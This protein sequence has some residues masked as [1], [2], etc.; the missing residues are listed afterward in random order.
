KN[1]SPHG[2]P[3]GEILLRDQFV[4]YV[5]DCALRR[6]LKQLVRRQPTVTLFDVRS[7]ALRWEREG[8]PGGVRGRSQ[9]VPSAYGIQYGVQGR[10]HL[11][12][13]SDGSAVSE[14]SE[15]RDMLRKQQQQLNQLS[16]SMSQLQNP[17][18]HPRPSRANLICRR[19]QKPGHFARDC[20]GE[21]MPVRPPPAHVNSA[22]MRAVGKLVPTEL[23]GRNLVGRRIGSNV[24]GT[25][26]MSRFM[27]SCP[28]LVVSM[29][30]VQVP[31]LVDTGSMVSTMTESCFM[32]NFGLWGQEQLR[33]CNWLQL[34]AANGLTIPYIGYL[35]LDVELCGRV[36]LGCGILVVRDPP[37]GVCAQVPGVLGMNILSRCYRELLGQHGTTLFDLPSVSRA[38]SFVFQALQHCHQVDAQP[39]VDCKGRVRVRGRRVCRITGGTMKFVAATCSVQYASGTVLFEPPTSGLPAGLLASPAL[40]RLDSGTVYVPIVNVGTMDVVLYA[41]TVIGTVNQVD[42]VSLPPEVAEVKTVTAKVSAQVVQVSPTVQEQIATLD[43]CVVRRRTGQRFRRIPPSEYEVVKAHINQLLETQVIR[44]S[45]SPYASPIVLVKKK[46]GSLRMCVDYRRLNSKTR[47]DAFPL[48]RIEETLDSLAG[49]RWFSTMDLASGYNQVPVAEGDKSKTAF[50][51]PFGLFEWNR[52]PFGLC[53]APSTFQHLME[54]LFGD[55]Q[56]QSLLLYL[57]DIIVF[58]SSVDQHLARLEVVLSRLQ[59]EGLKAKLSKCAFFKKEVHYLGH[60]ISSEGVSTDPGKVEAVAQ[61]PRPTNVSELRSFLGFASYYRRFVEGFAKLAAPLHRLVAQLANPKPLKRSAR[62]FAEAW[63]A[64]CQC[65]FEGLKGKLTTAPVLAYADFS[66]PFILEVDASHGGLGA[67]LS[68][69][70]QG[71]VRPIAYGSRSLRPTERNTTNYSS[72]KL[73]FLAL[74]WAMTE[75]FREYLLGHK[76]VVFTDNNPLSYLTSAKLGAMEQRWAAQVAAFDFEIKY[77]SGKS[78]RNADALSRQNF[79]GTVEVQELCPGVAVP[80]VL[81]QAA[82]VELVAQVNQVSS[83][84]CS[85]VSDMGAQ[86]IVDPVIGELLVFW[87]RKSPPTPEERKKLSKLAIILFRQWDRLVETDG[88]LYRRVFRP[89]G[90]E[91]V[92]Q[93][94]LPAVMKHEVLTQLHQQHGHQGVERTSQLV[95]QRCY[96]PGMSADIARWCQECERCQCAK[97]FPTA[98]GSFMGH[99]L[100]ARPNEILALD[101]TVLE[102]SRSGLENVL[103][104]TDIFT[105]YTL[106]VPTRDQ[107]AETVAQVLVVEWFCKFG[108]PGRIH[109]DQGRNFESTLI[110]QLCSLYGVEKSRTTPY[111]PAGNG[112]CERFN[113]TLH[114]LLRTLPLSKKGDWPFCLPQA[115]FAYNTTP[116]QAT[117]E[118]PHFLMFGQEPRLPVDFLLGRVQEPF[119]GSVHRWILEQQDR[120]QV[121]FKGAHERMGAAADRR[122]ARHDLQVKEAPL[123][124]GQLVYLRDY[125]VRGRCK[126]QDLW[127]SV[128][129]Q[130]LRAP[131][132]GGPVYTIAPTTDLSKVKQVHRSLL[133][134]LIGQDPPL[135]LPDPLVIEPLQ[136][137]EEEHDEEDLFVLAPETPQD[138]DHRLILMLFLLI[139]LCTWIQSLTLCLMLYDYRIQKAE[140]ISFCVRLLR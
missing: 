52:M 44:E 25:D 40:L 117:G 53:N 103:V 82:Q 126:I 58:S 139:K 59:R 133:K 23:Q 136:P 64:E 111:H 120:L 13:S 8:M 11:N 36:V 12:S 45:C 92:F 101:F 35:E 16:Q 18:S 124:E 22:L 24:T 32:T 121:A 106:A 41:S 70:Q 55:Q 54:R 86:Q 73:E 96:W 85:S 113:R 30:G 128:V 42:V 63:S 129:Y 56:C 34:R 43:L 134:A 29:G 119:A 28:Q 3:N 21:R 137:L 114:D 78:N 140:S 15:L 2:I 87:R 77:R 46:D 74:K 37:G 102:P 51:T 47:K 66:L 1:Q 33:S 104:M 17:Q 80:V 108:V 110:Q 84:P 69:E 50:C 57:D 125:S 48:P 19:C 99:L 10:Q 91:E 67:V 109:S 98:P 75:K 122:K 130:V 127:S 93:V 20:D 83:F 38:P 79:P 71:K 105:K 81:Q 138:R 89:D 115:L 68:Q 14:M 61:W 100:A 31:C 9:S 131:K 7:E 72:M 90:G 49:A 26:F 65:S 118:S 95:R 6:E 132:E 27:S 112:Q 76:C 94:L 116:H 97:G 62:E 39:A 4:E 123:K 135:E 60:V 88:V 5:N 107:R